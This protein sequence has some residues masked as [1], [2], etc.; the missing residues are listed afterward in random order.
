M[1]TTRIAWIKIGKQV[2]SLV[3]L[4]DSPYSSQWNFVLILEKN[5]LNHLAFSKISVLLS[6]QMQISNPLNCEN[7]SVGRAQPC[8]G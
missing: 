3:L 5:G 6:P 8:Q 2:K 4:D 1:R 7:S